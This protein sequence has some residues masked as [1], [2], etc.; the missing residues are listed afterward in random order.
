MKEVQ[1]PWLHHC[2]TNA[3][4]TRTRGFRPAEKCQLVKW[5]PVYSEEQSVFLQ[6]QECGLRLLYISKKKKKKRNHLPL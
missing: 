2:T 5:N 3:A 6:A 1:D 4:V